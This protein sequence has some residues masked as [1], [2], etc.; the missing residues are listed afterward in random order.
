MRINTEITLKEY[1]GQ[2]AD[3]EIT[4]R[5]DCSVYVTFK[6]TPGYGYPSLELSELQALIN[7]A[8]E[9]AT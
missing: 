5:T 7:K 8:K 2:R 6:M 1:A 3:V 4:V 9:L